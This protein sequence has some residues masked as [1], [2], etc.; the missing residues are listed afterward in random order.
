MSESMQ[1][2]MQRVVSSGGRIRERLDRLYAAIG[3]HYERQ[4]AGGAT[5]EEAYMLVSGIVSDMCDA[6]KIDTG[7]ASCMDAHLIEISGLID[8]D[9]IVGNI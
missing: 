7:V 4:I 8:D 9:D 2:I 6:G 1:D 5:P 3:R